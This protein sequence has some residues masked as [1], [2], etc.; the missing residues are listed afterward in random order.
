MN[1]EEKTFEETCKILKIE[2]LP[3]IEQKLYIISLYVDNL[4]KEKKEIQIAKL[5]VHLNITF[6]FKDF[7]DYEY[8]VN[9]LNNDYIIDSHKRIIKFSINDSSER[10]FIYNPDQFSDVLKEKNIELFEYSGPNLI[11]DE[12]NSQISE[13]SQKTINDCY[14]EDRIIQ[15]T[16]KEPK[17]S[18]SIEKYFKEKEYTKYTNKLSL[19]SQYSSDNIQNNLIRFKGQL[20]K[21]K[22]ETFLNYLFNDYSNVFF[23]S[24]VKGCGKTTRLLY[25]SH[26]LHLNPLLKVPRLYI[27]YKLMTENMVLKKSFLKKE[28]IFMFKDSKKLESL[29]KKGYHKTINKHENL[30]TFL[31]FFLEKIF[32]ENCLDGKK[33]LFIIDNFDDEKYDEKEINRL[34]DLCK[35]NFSKITIIIS[36]TGKFLREKRNSMYINKDTFEKE[37][38][39]ECPLYD[40]KEIQSNVIPHFIYNSP[41]YYFK[42][43]S[44][45]N[46]LKDIH[47]FSQKILKEEVEKLSELNFY[48]KYF[49]LI[50]EKE[51]LAK[52]KLNELFDIIP[53]NY[54][55][56]NFDNNKVYFT[57]QNE[58]IRIAFKK[59]IDLEVKE[60]AIRELINSPNTARTE[61]GVYN[62]KLLTIILKVNKVGLNNLN[63]NEDNILEVEELYDFRYCR[64]EKYFE[65][66]VP[67]EPIIITQRNFYGKNFDL[68]ILMPVKNTFDT[69]D[70]IF[71]Q[72]GLNKALKD[73]KYL[74]SDI[75][76]NCDYLAKGI[77]KYTDK[78]I[79]EVFLVFIFDKDTQT[80]MDEFPS[81]ELKFCLNNDIKFY[82]FSINESLL[83]NLIKKD[84]K[85]ICLKAEYF[86]YKFEDSK[87]LG[88][89]RNKLCEVEL[90]G[91][92]NILNN[93]DIEAINSKKNELKNT[94]QI[95]CISCTNFHE[96]MKKIS[97]NSIYL[98]IE[99]DTDERFFIIDGELKCYV[100]GEFVD[101]INNFGEEYKLNIYK[102]VLSNKKD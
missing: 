78:N 62:E 37:E 53:S 48:G 73:I 11:I 18:K 74:S 52:N 85:Y 43:I 86:E 77:N 2:D 100:D 38:Y 76:K 45:T 81:R 19:I 27:D 102:F 93:N 34:L 6:Q 71:I 50:N 98:V 39:I 3:L 21:Y 87:I 75:K 1:M 23:F 61:I 14:Y 96:F 55:F 49:C 26:K 12:V 10:R 22:S 13:I 47:L 8:C 30:F 16:R 72:I 83:Y 5:I 29:L 59:T 35:N 32:G 94:K 46:T 25:C 33:L 66:I 57:I 82:L 40:T 54:L 70:A 42:Y 9:L 20:D 79:K 31:T 101:Y 89:K 84:D 24:G 41:K 68:L 36:G 28:M 4:L 17:F 63:F 7:T 67:N 15:I 99:D 44:D 69:Y 92:Q 64:Y 80:K 60:K 97:K 88:K 56:F 90:F 51:K 58:I 95:I 91:L 65:N